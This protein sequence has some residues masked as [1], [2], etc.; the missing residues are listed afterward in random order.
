M[1]V[2][3][4]KALEFAISQGMTGGAG[5]FADMLATKGFES[6]V[7]QAAGLQ[8]ATATQLT[9]SLVQAGMGSASGAGAT[10]LS[11]TIGSIA[12]PISYIAA[13]DLASLE[14]K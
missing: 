7:S 4:P 11:S 3:G 10:G 1:N 2:L 8:G 6:L 14:D 5:T 13:A 9:P 12:T